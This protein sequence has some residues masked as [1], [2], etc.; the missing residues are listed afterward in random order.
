MGSSVTIS[1]AIDP[2]RENVNVTILYKLGGG[3]WTFLANETTDS[4]GNYSYPWT[5]EKVGTYQVKASWEGDPTTLGDESEV[6]TLTVKETAGIPIEYVVAAV[7][8]II[9]IVVIVV[10][11]VKIR[12]PEEE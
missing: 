1:G 7:V 3:A 4:N 9:I 6:Q 10:Y 12:K 5:P 8:G 11:F 2:A